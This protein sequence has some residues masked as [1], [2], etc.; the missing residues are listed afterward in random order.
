[1]DKQTFTEAQDR[2]DAIRKGDESVLNALYRETRPVFLKWAARRFS[3]TEEEAIEVYQKAFTVL[4]FNIR[5]GKLEQM[6]ASL[7]TYL[8]GIGKRVFFE[9]FRKKARE[10]TGLEEVPEAQVIDYAYLQQEAE[11]HRQQAVAS[12]LGKLGESCRQILRLYYFR[13]FSME[14]IASEMGYK[15]DKVAKKKKYECLKRLKK[16]VEDEGLKADDLF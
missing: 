3:C 14:S 10:S 15:N 7:E 9:L 5:D 8:I 11:N 16:T 4:Y 1:M 13:K 2:L 6:S 12:L